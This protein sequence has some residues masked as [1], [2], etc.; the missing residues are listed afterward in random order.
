M[1]PPSEALVPA[2]LGLG[3]LFWLTREAVAVVDADTAAIVLWNPAAEKLLGYSAA[4]IVG[5]PVEALLPG[6][7]R[8]RFRR[9]LDRL[10][11]AQPVEHAP[12][13][14]PVRT[15]TGAEAVVDVSV[16]T[17][18]DVPRGGRYVL[19]IAR[20]VSERTRAEEERAR[21]VHA[22]EARAEAEAA[23]TRLAALAGALD[24]ALAEAEL[25]NTIATRAANEDDPAR[26]LQ[27]TCLPLS[28]VVPFT[29]ASLAVV[30]GDEL[31]VRAAVGPFAQLALGQRLRRGQGR[32][33]QVLEDGRPLLSHDLL[34][35][36]LRPTTPL[37]SYL[38][39]PL[40]WRGRA[41][42]ILEVDSTTPNAFSDADQALLE[43]VGRTLSGLVELARRYAAEARALAASEQARQR[44]S[45]LSEAGKQLASSLDYEVMLRSVV[46]AAVPTLAEY[47][48]L[49]LV[50]DDG[51]ICRVAVAHVDPTQEARLRELRLAQPVEPDG[52]HPVARV[53]RSG[54]PIVAA[55]LSE[56]DLHALA[57]GDEHLALL[58]TL[59]ARANMTVPL[60]ARA[61]AL[62][63]LMFISTVPGRY[64]PDEL[65]LAEELAHRCAVAIDNARLYREARE[66]IKAR[67]EFLSVAAHELRTPITTLRASAQLTTRQLAK[68]ERA[69]GERLRQRLQIIDQQSARLTRLVAHLLDLSRIEAGKLALER[70]GVDVARLVRELVE[71]VRTR[72]TRHR[73]VVQAPPSARAWV[74]PVRLEQVVIN[75][76][77][78][79]VKYSPEDTSVEVDVS[80]PT[81]DTLRIAVRDHGTGI[82][83]ENRGHIFDRFYQ[84]HANSHASG[85]GLGLYISRQIVELHG[86]RIAAEFPPDGGT[87]FSI[88]LPTPEGPEPSHRLAEGAPG[89]VP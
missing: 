47:C 59:P 22:Q 32:L 29:G 60:V 77:D 68:G 62:G 73:L 86:G 17:V 79:A 84:A 11:A 21:R 12:L 66:A 51:V 40:V 41:F 6:R 65:A 89:G 13:T 87:R 69:D 20:D 33:W 48:T 74:D 43:K 53:L 34:A 24:R 78:N 15:R 82:P 28:R 46:R 8:A 55:D 10:R 67:D 19:A 61:R 9:V 26:M 50:Q 72:G 44:L 36:G 39:V 88:T 42:G 70:E 64:G 76:I 5:R 18:E 37:R 4:E 35:D 14:L 7:L 49:D 52:P 57:S 71:T 56:T 81:R 27:A 23:Q 30:E 75:L 80:T 31:V 58:R 3:R 16:S 2:D 54:E 1:A 85:M 25:L 38:A 45:F 63:G 83:P